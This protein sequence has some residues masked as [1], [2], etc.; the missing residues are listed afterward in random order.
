MKKVFITGGSG[1]IGSTFIRKNYGK[2]KFYS[3]SRN[4]KQQVSLKRRY[5]DV[6]T[7]LGTIEDANLLASEMLKVKP[8]IVVHTAAIKHIDIAERQPGQAININ[9]LGSANVVNASRICD[10][11][12]TVGISTDKACQ[13]DCVYGYTKLMMEKLF[14]DAN[15]SQ[16]RF[17][18]C[19]FGNVA[20]SHGSV[21]PYWISLNIKGQNIRLT[22]PKM[23][24]LMFLPTEAVELIEKSIELTADQNYQDGYVLSKKMKNVNMLRLSNVISDKVDIVGLRPG[25][26]LDEDLISEKEIEYSEVLEGGEYIVIRSEKNSD[27]DTRLAHGI[28]SKTAEEM[29]NE[30]LVNMV[31]SIRNDMVL[32]L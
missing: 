15:N 30:E 11:P 10:V 13:P 8:D 22:D 7:I 21:I 24:R 9:I 2:Y 26:K 14:S 20:G 4:E 28:C 1:T 19:R 5:P 3:Y 6:E 29:S 18:C 31:K 12:V 27:I 17:V 32:G 16:N 25:E 23:N